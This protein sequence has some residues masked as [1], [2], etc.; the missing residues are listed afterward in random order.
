MR[1]YDNPY[2]DS[3]LLSPNNPL[4]KVILI[5]GLMA[6]AAYCNQI[7]QWSGLLSG[8]T[9]SGSV[10]F[11]VITTGGQY[12]LQMVITNNATAVPPSTSDILTGIY[13]NLAG[14]PGALGMKSAKA[15]DG[16]LDATHQTPGTQYN[17]GT[18]ICA[19]AG[20]GARANLCATTLSGG[21]QTVYNPGGVGGGANAT[22]KYG[23]GTSGQGGV[24]S[25]NSVGNVN[26]GIAPS[27]G[28][29]VSL[30]GVSNMVPYSYNKVTIV[31]YGLIS[32]NVVVNNVEAAYGAAPDA[33]LDAEIYESQPEPG[34]WATIAGGLVA[35]MWLRRKAK[36]APVPAVPSPPAWSARPKP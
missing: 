23:V 27:A 8:Y 20:S 15:T 22:Q 13:F 25:G 30:D 36:P 1:G 9:L 18:N 35:M 31:L 6:P 26:Y 12:A 34:T 24:F 28:I 14:V 17:A 7:W 16:L 3:D 10:D 2:R 4:T 11:S 19:N 29:N 33:V 5:A 32:P 21:W